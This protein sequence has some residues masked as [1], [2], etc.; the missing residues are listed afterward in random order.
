MTENRKNSTLSL[1]CIAVL[2]AVLIVPTARAASFESDAASTDWD[3]AA[4]WTAGSGFPGAGDDVL[5]HHNRV[6]DGPEAFGSSASN[7]YWS[8]A[9]THLDLD[10]DTLTHSGNSTFHLT[11]ASC[12]IGCLGSPKGWTFSNA[13][14]STFSHEVAS[15]LTL[16]CGLFNSD[17]GGFVN[18]GTFRFTVPTGS[19]VATLSLAR[20][21]WFK[22][23]G[24]IQNISGG[25]VNIL[26][27]VAESSSFSNDVGAVIES[28]GD[29]SIL[30]VRVQRIMD[31]GGTW[32]A[33]TN[34]EVRIDALLTAGGVLGV[35]PNTVYHGDT[36][37]TG[38]VD[39]AGDWAV[40]ILGTAKGHVTLGLKNAL[41][42]NTD[43]SMDI[44]TTQA[45]GGTDANG[46]AG[47]I[48]WGGTTMDVEQYTLTLDSPVSISAGNTQFTSSG[49]GK[50]GRVVNAVGNT[51]THA[52]AGSLTIR[53]ADS[54][55][56]GTKF[57]NRGTFIFTTAIGSVA[58]ISPANA[59]KNISGATVRAQLSSG[60][61]GFT[62]S[63]ELSNQGTLEVLSGKLDVASTMK[64]PQ[65]DSGALT[66]GTYDVTG[67]LDLNRAASITIIDTNTIVRLRGSSA[68]FTE[69]DGNLATVNGS[70]GLYSGMVYNAGTSLTVAGTLEFGLSDSDASASVVKTGISNAVNV[71]LTGG[72][73]D[74]ID[75]GLTGPGTFTLIEHTGTQTGTLT[76][77]AVPNDGLNY[78]LI[79]NAQN[80]QLNAAAPPSGAVYYIE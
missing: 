1:L 55:T 17:Q 57:E 15:T 61:C 45:A 63:G 33:M 22:N 19:A 75:V 20:S 54:A 25:Q 65:F 44:D 7:S 50:T 72:E 34:A 23:H 68:T 37:S 11:A 70:F 51:F 38:V 39:I 14:G 64:F 28:L 9:S 46:V 62:S 32:L 2:G 71:V 41:R 56:A 77:D 40:D 30:Q 73:V 18:N 42:I 49:P 43:V 53:C 47:T 36:A 12:V 6:I 80:V 4:A 74:V 10:A 5:I 52:R 21:V 59:F 16:T 31:G 76:L 66:G 48:M 8:T 58:A 24:K 79:H 13:V 27:S 29:G 78:T 67:T 69:F 3:N 60:S 35:S 26:N